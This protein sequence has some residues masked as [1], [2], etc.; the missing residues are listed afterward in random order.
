[1]SAPRIVSAE[2]IQTSIPLK[3]TFKNAHLAKQAQ[4]SVIVRLRSEDGLEGLGDVDPTPGYTLETPEE[5]LVTLRQRLFPL[6][7]EVDPFD[8]QRMLAALERAAPEAYHARAALEM[9]LVDLEAQRCGVPVWRLLGGAPG[10]GVTFNGW[11]GMDPPSAAADVA[12]A[13]AAAGFRSVKVKVGSRVGED[14]E[15]VAAVRAALGPEA[16]IRVD[17]NE[18]FDEEAAIAFGRGVARYAPRLLEQPLPREDLEGL[19]RVRRAVDVPIMADESVSGPQSVA[20]I[21]RA[22]AADIIKVK[23]MKQGGVRPTLA[24][25]RLAEHLG[26]AC[27]I[28]HG[29]GLAINTLAEIHVACAAPNVLPGCEAVGPLKMTGDVFTPVPDLSAGRAP[30]PTAPGLGAHLDE[31]ALAR[32]RVG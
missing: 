5:I 4:S 20:A 19:A 10:G 22:G 31:Q 29:F 30:A 23:V 6:L 24:M 11:V 3:G 7:G 13:F 2:A 1:M 8:S 15:R 27:V 32:Y 26:L 28:G 16:E 14:L 25:I 18:G 21:H 12:R 17:A 9:A